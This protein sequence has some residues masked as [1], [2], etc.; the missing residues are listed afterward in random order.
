MVGHYRVSRSRW[1]DATNCVV[2]ENPLHRELMEIA[3]MAGVDFIVNVVIDEDRDLCGVYSGHYDEA[4]RAGVGFAM[5]YDM[6][7]A[8]EPADIVVT[9]SAGYP[10]DKTYYQ[11]IKGMVGALNI[12]KERG[13]IVIASECS[14]GMGNDTFV[15]CLGK[16]G[17][18]GD[19]EKYVEYLSEPDNYVP[20]QWQVEKLLEAL[21]K[22]DVILVSGGLPDEDKKLTQVDTSDTLG[23]ALAKCLEKH[24]A[25]AKVAVIPEGPYVIPCVDNTACES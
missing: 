21:R 6:V 17:E 9:S 2:A 25:D 3:G 22:A 12:V 10:L 16:F 11:T 15:D 23:A 4:H 24:G 8:A 18:I 19:I 20:D 7:A 13:T 1:R 14:E 5:R